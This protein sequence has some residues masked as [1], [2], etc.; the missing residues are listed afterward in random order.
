MLAGHETTSTA[1]A[2]ALLEV[3]Q[4]PEL[5]AELRA[6]LHTLPLP[7]ASGGCAPLDADKLGALDKLPILDAV[8]R[9]TL[10]LCPP[11]TDVPRAAAHDVVIP[12]AQPFVDAR[13]AAQHT[14][15]IP[16][17]VMLTVPISTINR[18]AELWGPD[19]MEWKYAL[20][21]VLHPLRA[22]TE[23]LLQPPQMAWRHAGSRTRCAGRVEQYRK[24]TICLLICKA[25]TRYS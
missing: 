18:A 16:A 19:A 7:H 3:C 10:R 21:R 6:E 1:L 17:G 12:L 20:G 24:P 11:I 2:W 5:Q 23:C 13:G 22:L 14:L 8:L 25:V 9:E 15:H 4:H